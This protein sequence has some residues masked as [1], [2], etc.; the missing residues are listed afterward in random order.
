MKCRQTDRIQRKRAFVAIRYARIAFARGRF[1][2]TPAFIC[3]RERQLF[4]IVQH[5]P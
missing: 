5:A 2:L 4:L 3:S 1:S